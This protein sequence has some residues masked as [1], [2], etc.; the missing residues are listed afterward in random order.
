[1]RERVQ[2][3][4]TA[5]VSWS[6][7]NAKH[8]H[9]ENSEP[10]SDVVLPSAM[11]DQAREF[12]RGVSQVLGKLTGLQKQQLLRILVREALFDGKQVIIKGRIPLDD[13]SASE[14]F[15]PDNPPVSHV[16]KADEFGRIAA[17]TPGRHGRNLEEI[18]QISADPYGNRYVRNSAQFEFD[19]VEQIE[20]DHSKANAARRLNLIKAMGARWPKVS[21]QLPLH[22]FSDEDRTP[23]RAN[24]MHP[25]H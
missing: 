5:N 7:R 23:K 22:Q 6:P 4:I 14:G 2:Q 24:P 9:V 15:T 19:L 12:C 17:L 18:P 13:A 10:S 21:A 3:K 20:V 16:S 8:I 25:A 11:E 1:M